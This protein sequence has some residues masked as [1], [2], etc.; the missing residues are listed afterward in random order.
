ML[1]HR[2]ETARGHR[3]VRALDAY[4]LQITEHRNVL[5]QPGGGLADHDTTGRGDGF[6]PL[7]HTDL[8]TDGGVTERP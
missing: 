2:H 7:R 6:H 4:H 3:C 5:D 1:L 8:L